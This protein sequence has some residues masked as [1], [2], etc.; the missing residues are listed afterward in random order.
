M[1][2]S[3]FAALAAASFSWEQLYVLTAIIILLLFGTKDQSPHPT[4]LMGGPGS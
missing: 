4:T 3:F 2:A 1:L